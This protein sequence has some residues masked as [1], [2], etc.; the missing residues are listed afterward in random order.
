MLNHPHLLHLHSSRIALTYT[1]SYPTNFPQLISNTA[2]HRHRQPFPPST[3]FEPLS[4]ASFTLT[5]API[6]YPCSSTKSIPPLL[7]L[8]AFPVQN[9]NS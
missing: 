7:H 5:S 1:L 9:R 6:N 3:S 2:T 4:S 8:P